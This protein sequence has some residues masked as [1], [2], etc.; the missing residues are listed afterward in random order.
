MEIQEDNYQQ[1]FLNFE[2]DESASKADRDVC[3]K[4]AQLLDGQGNSIEEEI[5]MFASSDDKFKHAFMKAL[6]SYVNRD[7]Q[8]ILRRDCLILNLKP[9]LGV[10]ILQGG[11]CLS[12]NKLFRKILLVM[13]SPLQQVQP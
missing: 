9:G 5:K 12:Q 7:D 8:K 4:I 3:A 6:S 10:Q 13:V 11:S 1:F 2:I